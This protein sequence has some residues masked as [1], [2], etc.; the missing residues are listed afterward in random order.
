MLGLFILAYHWIN[1]NGVKQMSAH[2]GRSGTH[3][4]DR[5]RMVFC[6]YEGST[7]SSTVRRVCSGIVP[8]SE[9]FLVTPEI[10]RTMLCNRMVLEVS[11]SSHTQAPPLAIRF[12]SGNA[13]FSIFHLTCIILMKIFLCCP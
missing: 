11:L 2:D 9:R 13:S 10:F 7:L 6:P 8:W 12:L 1:A 3:R 5:K 4:N